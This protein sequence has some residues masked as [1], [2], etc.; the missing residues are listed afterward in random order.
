MTR[1]VADVPVDGR[2]TK[3]GI[4]REVAYDPVVFLCD[5]FFLSC[6]VLFFAQLP[7]VG[8]LSQQAPVQ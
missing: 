7:E 3:L 5:V 8:R 1:A 4:F 2:K 6:D